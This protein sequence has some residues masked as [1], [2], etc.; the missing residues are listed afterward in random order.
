MPDQD[1]LASEARALVLELRSELVAIVEGA[2]RSRDFKVADERLD[3][4]KSRAVELIA[5]RIN[6]REA[7]KLNRK[8]MM[9]FSLSDPLRDITSEAKMYDSFLQALEEDLEARPQSILQPPRAVQAEPVLPEPSTAQQPQSVFIIHGRDELNLLR[10]KELLRE[11]WGLESIVMTGQPGKGRTLIEKFEQEAQTASFALALLTPDDV[12]K[13]G[14]S[15]YAQ[16]RPNVV[17]E[18]G[19]FYGRLGRDK[20]C[21]LF[22]EGTTIHSD[23]DGLSRIQF[24]ESVIEKV[25]EIEREFL[26]AEIIA[27]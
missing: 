25:S 22:R 26:A 18:L 14:E 1:T 23:L 9:S 3:R 17:F 8:R 20:V 24:S 27:A 16:A 6:P 11:R 19:W 12:V 13:L 7:Q 4:W 5:A 10:L 2:T 15:Q 21:I